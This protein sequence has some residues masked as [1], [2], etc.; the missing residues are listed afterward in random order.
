MSGTISK[1]L[2][3]APISLP[4]DAVEHLM[5]QIV[6]SAPNGFALT[7]VDG[8]IVVAN[9]ELERMFGYSRRELLDMH[10]EAL[11]PERFRSGHAQLRDGNWNDFKPRTMG[12]GRE[13]FGLKSD[14]SEFPIEIGINALVA[15]G[16]TM[17]VESIADISVRKRLERMFQKIVEATPCGI[18]MIDAQGRIVLAN[19]QA[20]LMFGYSLAELIGNSLEILL[21]ERLRAAHGVH[22]H[23]FIAA[24][25]IRQMGVGRDL[26]ARRKDGSEFPVEIGL[27]PVPGDRDGMVLAAVTDI[28]RRNNMQLELRQANANLEE[29][30]YAASHDLKSP[31]RGIADLVEWIVEDLGDKASPEIT[32]NLGRVSER[33]KRLD[34]VVD[35]LLAYARA[36][37]PASEAVPV[38]VKSLI[39]CVL[40]LL[41]RPAGF[42]VRSRVD[43]RP[44]VT[45][46]TPLES[47]LRNLVGNAVK[48]H[49][50]ASGVIEICV[51][52][53]G[54]YCVFTVSDDGPGIAPAYQ[55]RVFRMFQTL[56]ANDPNSSG[57][58]L[59]L[60]KR[61]VEAHGG[62]I[63]LD[64]IEGVR[65]TAFHVWWPRF[66][67]RK[68]Y[69]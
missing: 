51:E 24:P 30:T 15:L 45:N 8:R 43:A 62:W 39:D 33:V 22:R 42:L 54:R 4:R 16:G 52:D 25:A 7:A 35:D 59:A 46:K 29:F 20:E 5:S 31:L 23:A 58:G 57:I 28:T 40:E 66:Q 64:S 61:L 26:T 68:N 21:P 63:K 2:P 13:L 55:E 14:G 48:H 18:I 9:A 56:N 6:E 38:D 36:G 17:V 67:W 10:I 19:P 69:D 44:F 27:N 53:V 50:R 1:I 49:D 32:R 65:G 3:E 11:L 34:R 12:A 37:A 41:P 60:S 47:V